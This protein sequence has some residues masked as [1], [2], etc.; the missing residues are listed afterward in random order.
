MDSSKI[1]DK[2]NVR[3][4]IVNNRQHPS[5]NLQAREAGFEIYNFLSQDGKPYSLGDDAD[6]LK[7][8][9]QMAESI[10]L[11]NGTFLG[12]CLV[13]S[14][15]GGSRLFVKEFTDQEKE[16]F[17]YAHVCLLSTMKRLS[18]E[19]RPETFS[20]FGE[21]NLVDSKEEKFERESRKTARVL[22]GEERENWLEIIDKRYQFLKTDVYVYSLLKLFSWGFQ[23]IESEGN[24]REE[25]N[26]VRPNRPKPRGASRK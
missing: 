20:F 14:D 24:V 6:Y 9:M 22:S 21:L 11:N 19:N 3:D 17:K 16:E 23:V 1:L 10:Y 12:T 18:D 13:A 7:L 4:G 5:L 26:L 25:Q 8:F 2:L 15:M